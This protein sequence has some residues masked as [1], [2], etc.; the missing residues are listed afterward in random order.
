MYSLL[1]YPIL[2]F[3]VWLMFHPV[4][5]F[6][7]IYTTSFERIEVMFMFFYMSKSIQTYKTRII[8]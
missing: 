2:E 6:Q 7:A 1:P 3:Y 5:H 4:G 8:R